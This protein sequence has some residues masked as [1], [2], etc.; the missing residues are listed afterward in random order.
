VV[1]FLSEPAFVARWLAV[2][3]AFVRDRVAALLGLRS[4]WRRVFARADIPHTSSSSS[5][6]SSS[7]S[8]SSLSSSS[9]SSLGGQGANGRGNENTYGSGSGNEQEDENDDEDADGGQLLLLH[10]RWHCTRA[11][12]ALMT[13]LD[14]SAQRWRR[15]VTVEHVCMRDAV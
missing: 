5:S 9:L 11:A 3:R 12:D 6:S 14:A 13:V 15:A 1:P 7:L 8:S 2:D 10:S 4:A